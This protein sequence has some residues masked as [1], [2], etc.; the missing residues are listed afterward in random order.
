MPGD[1][2]TPIESHRPRNTDENGAALARD[3]AE[4]RTRARANSRTKCSR[5]LGP[6]GTSSSHGAQFLE[7]ELA[8][9]L[10]DSRCLPSRRSDDASTV[11][12]LTTDNC[13][14]HT[15]SRRNGSVWLRQ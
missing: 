7:P 10:A 1:G 13:A 5:D 14:D 9:A 6:G 12:A 15:R 8:G 4:N 2:R 11:T 3:G